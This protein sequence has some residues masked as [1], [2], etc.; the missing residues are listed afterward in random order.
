[1]SNAQMPSRVHPAAQLRIPLPGCTDAGQGQ[2]QSSNG[3]EVIPRETLR[4]GIA[5]HLAEQ[6]GVES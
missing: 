5:W 6:G 1:M 2:N 4:A 3:H